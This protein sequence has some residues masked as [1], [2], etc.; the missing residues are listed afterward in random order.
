MLASDII[1]RAWQK[2]GRKARGRSLSADDTTDGLAELVSM[3]NSLP[4]TIYAYTIE[5]ATLTSGTASYTIGSGADINTTKPISIEFA[6]IRD[7]SNYDHEITLMSQDQYGAEYLKN[8]SAR[9]TGLYYEKGD[10]TGTI[11]LNRKPTGETLVIHSLK[12]VTVPTLSTDEVS[13]PDEYDDLL[14]YNLAKRLGINTGRPVAVDILRIAN[15]TMVAMERKNVS[16]PVMEMPG[17]MIRGG[18]SNTI[19]EG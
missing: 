10:A 17:G 4:V 9:P 2:V 16:V 12:P 5:T 11:Y 14:V 1:S 3:I 18:S 19:N 6:A 7:S 8:S 15:S 13:L